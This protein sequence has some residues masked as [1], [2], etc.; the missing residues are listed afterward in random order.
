MVKWVPEACLVLLD[1]LVSEEDEVFVV[2]Q[3][4]LDL[5]E[6]LVRQEVEACLEM[7]DL[8]DQK[9]RPVIEEKQGQLVLKG[10]MEM[11][12]DQVLLAYKVF[13]E[14]LVDVGEWDDEVPL[15]LEESLVLMASLVKLGLKGYKD[16]LGQ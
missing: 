2:H 4:L 8:L 6:S 5:P 13:A 3:D 9:G 7:M 12:E 16:A 1:Q 10:N 15:V 14:H 11:W